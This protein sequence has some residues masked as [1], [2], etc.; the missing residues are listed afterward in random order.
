MLRLVRTPAPTRSDRE[1]ASTLISYSP[2]VGNVYR[3]R[4]AAPR[5]DRQAVEMVVLLQVVGDPEVVHVRER[6]RGAQGERG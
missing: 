1:P 5:T 3:M 4:R 6:R 2:S